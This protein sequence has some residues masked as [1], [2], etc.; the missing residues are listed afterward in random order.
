MAGP[1]RQDGAR[2]RVRPWWCARSTL[3]VRAWR[4]RSGGASSR[5]PAVPGLVSAGGVMTRP[6]SW[7]TWWWRTQSG[8]GLA[9]EVSPPCSRPRT[10]WAWVRSTWTRHPGEAA[11]LVAG[12]EGAAHPRR[13]G[14]EVTTDIEDR[15]RP[16][17]PPLRLADAAVG[18][19]HTVCEGQRQGGDDRGDGRVAQDAVDRR[20]RREHRLIDP[21]HVG[22]AHPPRR[23]GQR[24]P[25]SGSGGRRCRGG[26]RPS[27][28]RGGRAS[29]RH[30]L[31]GEMGG[32]D[33][34][35]PDLAAP[36]ELIVVGIH[37]GLVQACR[38][39]R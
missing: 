38:G 3:P 4:C 1:R 13:D 27:R 21:G 34:H 37:R 25:P 28:G 8:T 18:R 16:V 20:T 31:V 36:E 30:R 5:Y 33:H 10:W 12:F 35:L 14:P 2:G 23:P 7:T 24:R 26:S 19:G 17:L 11:V 22:A 39:R 15:P 6:P 29:W 32:D 9:R